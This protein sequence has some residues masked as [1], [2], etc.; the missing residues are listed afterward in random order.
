ML[1]AEIQR[2]SQITF[3]FLKYHRAC[4]HSPRTIQ[5]YREKLGLFI[6]F[7]NSHDIAGMQDI[8]AGLI[9]EFILELQQTHNEGGVHA[10]FRS[11]RAL[12]NWYEFE[13][14]PG[15]WKNPI[16]KVKAPRV[17]ENLLD[18]VSQEVVDLLINA[19][20]DSNNCDRDKAVVLFLQA[21]GARASEVLSVDRNDLDINA[22]YAIV[23]HGKG[24][25]FRY[26]FFDKKT[27]VAIKKYLK[28]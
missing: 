7:L 27:R 17:S 12:M 5:F 14:E 11:I 28:K 26:I 19:C 3:E 6:K 9:R 10:F 22:C 13:Y 8:T 24:G 20:Q 2:I 21:T 1:P 16:D 15:E 25:Y 23:R 4:N 18:P